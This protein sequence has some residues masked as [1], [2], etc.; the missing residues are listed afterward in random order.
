[1]ELDRNKLRRNV[2]YYAN[3]RG[4]KI[5]EIERSIG[6][7]AGHI[8]R[9][10]KETTRIDLICV[11]KIS[12][13]LDVTIDTLIN[14]DIELK[15]KLQEIATLK[16]KINDITNKTNRKIEDLEEQIKEIEVTI[17]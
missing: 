9:W 8:S 2:L 1:M 6:K 10:E 12:I 16:R 5:G 11:Y 15:A 7:P 17:K 14:E 13:I 3:L 4:L